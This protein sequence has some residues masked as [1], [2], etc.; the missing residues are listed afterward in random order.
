MID[1]TSLPWFRRNQV[2]SSQRGPVLD[3][4]CGPRFDVFAT[5]SQDG[6]VRVWDL[7]NFGAVAEASQ[8][9]REGGAISALCLCWLREEAVVTGWSDSFVRCVARGIE[10]RN[11]PPPTPPSLLPCGELPGEDRPAW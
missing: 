8:R 11:P 5:C 2:S 9:S 4:A 3:V 1:R 7:C 10:A 6:M